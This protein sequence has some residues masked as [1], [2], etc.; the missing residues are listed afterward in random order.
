MERNAEEQAQTWRYVFP[1][2]LLVLW[3]ICSRIGWISSIYLPSPS[4]IIRGVADL[5]IEKDLLLN[6]LDTVRRLVIGFAIGV[7]AGLVAGLLMVGFRRLGR[8]FDPILTGLNAIP[9]AAFLP[10]VVI[11]LGIGETSKL[12]IIALGAFFPVAVNFREGAKRVN[13]VWVRAALN[14]GANRRQVL[15]NVVMPALMPEL[16]AGLKLGAGLALTLVVYAEMVGVTSGIGYLLQNQAELF[17]LGR[18]YAALVIL[19]AIAV[20]AQKSIA[21]LQR[22]YCQWQEEQQPDA[23]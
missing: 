22:R 15:L 6:L 12:S 8:A 18:A 1:V 19:I 21:S 23:S 20:I 16:F 10:I 13:P 3:D 9:K 4:T 5:F 17:E 14:L 11:W 2:C 7:G